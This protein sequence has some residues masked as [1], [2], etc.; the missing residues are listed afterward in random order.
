MS[1]YVRTYLCVRD[2]KDRAC[3]SCRERAETFRPSV[4]IFMHISPGFR[5]KIDRDTCMTHPL[6]SSSSNSCWNSELHFQSI[7]VG[8]GSKPKD[9]HF[10]RQIYIFRSIKSPSLHRNSAL[11]RMTFPM[12]PG[13]EM[14]TKFITTWQC[15][16][17]AHTHSHS[18]V[19]GL[20]IGHESVKKGQ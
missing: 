13:Y 11:I 2:W 5:R 4:R 14:M 18:L 6:T 19:S 1:T 20:E 17:A 12:L 16:R 9:S 8:L 3:A 15:S 10:W 7:D